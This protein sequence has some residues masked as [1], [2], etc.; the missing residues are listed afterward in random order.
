MGRIRSA[1]LVARRRGGRRDADRE[2]VGVLEPISPELVLVDPELAR[3]ERARLSERAQLQELMR[4]PALGSRPGVQTETR[5]SRFRPVLL[6]LSLFACGVL[7][8]S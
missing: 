1:P 2:L 3:V 5:P 8:G 6:G 4:P 7:A